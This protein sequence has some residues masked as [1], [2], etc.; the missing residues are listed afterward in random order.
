MLI[1]IAISD[2][3]EPIAAALNGKLAPAQTLHSFTSKV[4]SESDLSEQRVT[5]S[6]A[7]C[8]VFSMHSAIP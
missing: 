3:I 2:G 4:T 7:Q 1:F 8:R 5:E 6:A